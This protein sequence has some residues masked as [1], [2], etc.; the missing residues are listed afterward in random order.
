MLDLSLTS[1]VTML[2]QTLHS[3]SS[4]WTRYCIA[5]TGSIIWEQWWVCRLQRM[6]T[7]VTLCWACH[8]GEYWKVR[9]FVSDVHLVYYMT[10][11][12]MCWLAGSNRAQHVNVSPIH[13]IV[14]KVS[15]RYNSIS[16]DSHRRCQLFART[17][18]PSLFQPREQKQNCS[19]MFSETLLVHLFHQ[20]WEKSEG[21]GFGHAGNQ[22][23]IWNW[24]G[25]NGWRVVM[26]SVSFG[27]S[28][29]C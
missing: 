3:Q 1:R 16:H 7:E 24:P 8:I 25:C 15:P 6:G 22:K 26:F 2:L 9:F 4:Q 20:G 19:P 12:V 21:G 11:S 17:L 5:L 27:P 23:T 18:P 29:C 10:S 28:G 13:I 14:T